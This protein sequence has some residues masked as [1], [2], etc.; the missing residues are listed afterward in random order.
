MELVA[1]PGAKP[2]LHSPFLDMSSC[3]VKPATSLLPQ[4]AFCCKLG[5]FGF[6]LFN[7][8]SYHSHRRALVVFSQNTTILAQ[9]QAGILHPGWGRSSVNIPVHTLSLTHSASKMWQWQRTRE[10]LQKSCKFIWDVKKPTLIQRENSVPTLGV[11]EVI[12][13][14]Q[15]AAFCL[16][17]G[18]SCSKI[19]NKLLE[20]IIFPL[21]GAHP[22][23]HPFLSQFLSLLAIFIKGRHPSL[24]E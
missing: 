6:C 16:S 2:F 11:C 24:C 17:I 5:W 23:W 22:W 19:W 13:A 7:L 21:I 15:T 3:S 12:E 8:T 4:S 9:P 20:I 1:G 18:K 10:K 14:F